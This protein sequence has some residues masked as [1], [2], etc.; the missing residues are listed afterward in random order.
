MKQLHEI[1]SSENPA[2]ESLKLA[3]INFLQQIENVTGHPLKHVII[4]LHGIPPSFFNAE[5]IRVISQESTEQ[6]EMLLY[7]E[8]IKLDVKQ[9]YLINIVSSFAKLP[10][11]LPPVPPAK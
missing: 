10:D 5:A 1:P 11:Q 9:S 6:K 8:E 7:Y 4:S 2:K 3:I